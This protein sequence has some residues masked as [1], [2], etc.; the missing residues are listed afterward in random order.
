M[1]N[2]TAIQASLDKF[3][4]ILETLLLSALGNHKLMANIDRLEAPKGVKDSPV[5]LIVRDTASRPTAVVL[6]SSPVSPNLVSRGMDL[7][8][9]AKQAMGSELGSVIL[10]P[11]GRG[12]I[13]GRSYTILPYCRPMFSWK[14]LRYIQRKVIRPAVINWLFGVTKQTKS[15]AA[16]ESINKDFLEPLKYMTHL[17]T[18]GEEVNSAS[19]RALKRLECGQWIPHHVLMHN[20]LWEGNILPG[21]PSNQNKTYKRSYGFIIIDWPGCQLKGYPIY[22]LVR[23]SQSLRLN[24]RQFTNEL[25][26]HCTLLGCTQEDSEGYLLSAL[27]NIGLNPEHFP[28]DAYVRLIESCYHYLNINSN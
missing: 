21:K 25:K 1:G 7:A 8:V 28:A 13:E 22:D 11:L 14:P 23:L 10:D 16:Q 15:I 18:A 19:L 24:S 9:Q 3:N 17:Q 26:R 2:T 4:K 27:G 6:Y 12:D 20:D 5:K